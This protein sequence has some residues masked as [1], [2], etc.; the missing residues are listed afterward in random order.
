LALCYCSFSRHLKI[1]SWQFS[2][3]YIVMG[4]LTSSFTIL[5]NWFLSITLKGGLPQIS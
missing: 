4:N 2:L 5:V 3:I 1:K